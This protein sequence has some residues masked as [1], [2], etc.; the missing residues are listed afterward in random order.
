MELVYCYFSE[1]NGIEDIGINLSSR[2]QFTFDKDLQLV[3]V[4]ENPNYL[5]SFFADDNKV[6]VIGIV[7]ENGS[8]KSSILTEIYNQDKLDTSLYIFHDKVDEKDKFKVYK[9]KDINFD[10]KKTF[11]EGQFEENVL[12]KG[13]PFL[14]GSSKLLFKED[15]NGSGSGSMGVSFTENLASICSTNDINSNL[16]FMLKH[17]FEIYLKVKKIQQDG[18]E[19]YINLFNKSIINAELLDNFLIANFINIQESK[20][21]EKID[22]N[23]LIDISN[24]NVRISPYFD[25]S[26]HIK[27]RMKF[28]KFVNENEGN[29]DVLESTDFFNNTLTTINEK[30]KSEFVSKILINILIDLILLSKLDY[31]KISIDTLIGSVKM[32][33]LFDE[34]GLDK[35]LENTKKDD[36]KIIST[37]VEKIIRV[38]VYDLKEILD[39]LG[40]KKLDETK[41]LTLSYKDEK[42][43]EF[44]NLIKEKI[45]LL[46]YFKIENKVESIDTY[47]KMPFSSGELQILRLIARASFYVEQIKISDENILLLLDEPDAMLHPN[48]QRL[49][50]KE[51]IP[52][53]NSVTDKKI[54][55]LFTT[56]SPIMITD[57]PK[58]NLNILDQNNRELSIETFGANIYSLYKN[59]FF[60]EKPIGAFALNKIDKLYKKLLSEEPS[61]EDELKGFKKL[62]NTIGEPLIKKDLQYKLNNYLNKFEYEKDAYILS[63]LEKEKDKIESKINDIRG[64]DDKSKS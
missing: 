39:I 3:K 44:V 15:Y 28:A 43:G 19:N 4:K 61:T 32:Y 50:W 62:I 64:R 40:I 22:S 55:I 16:N 14:I 60:L 8:G 36:E 23:I 30:Y 27:K 11:E 56:H 46:K 12:N 10:L 9:G 33:D 53:I 59:T 2:F 31:N 37:S 52:L 13:M 47:N 24:K 1:L 35:F 48:W 20:K 21:D 26:T 29:E 57:I 58:A 34:N 38:I 63:E 7:G 17:D 45:Y 6:D 41:D 42:L 49:F 54:K 18:A 25:F 5:D 51:F